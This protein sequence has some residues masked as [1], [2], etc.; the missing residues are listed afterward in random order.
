MKIKKRRSRISVTKA[1]TTKVSSTLTFMIR[2]EQL[3]GE[4]N[5]KAT[6]MTLAVQ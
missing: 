3:E 1:A 2:Q 5:R 4:S 6:T